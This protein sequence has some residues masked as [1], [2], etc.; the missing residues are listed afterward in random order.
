MTYLGTPTG[1]EDDR[2]AE[3]R[4]EVRGKRYWEQLLGLPPEVQYANDRSIFLE[5]VSGRFK[6]LLLAG[7]E[8]DMVLLGVLTYALLDILTANTFVAIF[9]TYAMDVGVRAVRAELA[10]RNIATK[11]LLDDR[12]LL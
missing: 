12:F 3:G 1:G 11:T 4:P 9:A 6:R 10:T 5:D 8:Q 2:P 7:R